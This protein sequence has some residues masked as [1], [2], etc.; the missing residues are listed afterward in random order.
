MAGLFSLFSNKTRDAALVET[1]VEDLR[2]GMFVVL[3]LRWYEHPFAFN[4]FHLS[5][6]GQIDTLKSLGLRTVWSD[7]AQRREAE[8]AAVET[9]PETSPQASFAEEQKLKA[10]QVREIREQQGK[11][12]QCEKRYDYA[13]KVAREVMQTLGSH[14]RHAGEK[15]SAL[16]S[17]I[18]N[19]LDSNGNLVVHL[20]AP[21]LDDGSYHHA[22]NV[23]ILSLILGKA[24]KLPAPILVELGMAG[25]FHDLGKIQVSSRVLKTPRQQ[26]TG[27][28]RAL[29]EMHPVYGEQLATEVPSL[30][31]RVR[32]VIRHHHE[33]L[34]G[35]GF[36]DKLTGLAINVLMHVVAIT[37]R[38]DNLCNP[39]LLED[40]LPPSAAMAQM[41][42]HELS[43]FSKA[44]L[45]VFV[46]LMGVYPP[47]TLVEL[48]TGDIGLVTSVEQQDLLRPNVL[49]YA[50]D[51]PP[52]DAPVIRLIQHP[53]IRVEKTLRRLACPEE[54]RDYLSPRS[55]MNYFFST[56]VAS[57]KIT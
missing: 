55:R 54:V 39:M 6:Q 36:P 15:A 9:A 24:L 45:E 14:P 4:Q 53:E 29:Y 40:A 28:E 47:G 30:S 31:A 57:R 37:N 49:L 27:P 23:M 32:K 46:K 10:A 26:W 33:R 51:V 35:Q 20:M 43:G 8:T 12:A 11:I 41:Y 7:P 2:L 17:D 22:L 52:R 38:Y 13:A 25:L 3:R 48:S 21:K 16:V 19:V 42:K 34:D 56:D 1:P 5:S 50:P 44:V 18:V